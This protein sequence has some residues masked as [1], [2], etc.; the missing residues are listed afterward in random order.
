MARFTGKV[1]LITGGTSGIGKAAALAFA[2]E[3]AK[4][5]VSGRREP[6]GLAV[7]EQVKTAGGEA[8]FV[9]ADVSKE[10]DV[11]NLVA[12]T[13]AR[14]GRLDVAFNNAGVES[15]APAAEFTEAEYRKVFDANVLGV[16]L[17]LKYELPELVKTGGV[18][19][20]TSSV[21]G[22]V[23]MPN[24]SVY[25]ASKH[26]VEG[27]T[28]AVALEYA[29][30]G[31]RVFAVA[32]A[33]IE[34]DMAERFTGGL[35]TDMGRQFAGMHPLGRAGKPEEVAAAVLFLA[36]PASSFMTGHSLPVDGGWLAQ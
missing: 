3:G 27:I 17:S 14:Y 29:K 32:P 15:A 20:N 19:V 5:A 12:Q 6:E 28:K 21:A 26:A 7:V 22:H 36:S 2:G 10:A 31:V 33:L 8:H 24:T 30:Q 25:I 11:K 18:V 9:K 34:T 4:V 16:F 13:V 1:V 23:G 35:T